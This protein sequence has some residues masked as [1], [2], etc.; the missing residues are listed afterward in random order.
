MRLDTRKTGLFLPPLGKSEQ[1]DQF[2]S[3]LRCALGTPSSLLTAVSSSRQ[4]ALFL[5]SGG[6]SP[7]LFA[8][9]V[10]QSLPSSLVTV[11]DLEI[12]ISRQ[13]PRIEAKVDVKLLG[14]FESTVMVKAQL[15]VES[16]M[17]FSET[18]ES[19]TVLDRTVDLPAPV[20]YS[21]DLY[22]TYVDEDLLVV[23]DASGVPEV[24]VRKNKTFM[25]NW[26][27]EPS[28]IDDMVAPGEDPLPATE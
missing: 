16:G 28:A 4:L 8:L 12:S 5:Y 25:G 6:Y 14:G 7:G 18:Y 21:R 13:Q 15:N 22:V 24:L 23:R 17:R 9:S 2:V 20:Q 3:L 27:T 10:A 19:A 11:G 1:A 26:G